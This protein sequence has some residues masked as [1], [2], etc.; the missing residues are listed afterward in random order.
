METKP[1]DGQAR[2]QALLS[3]PN[4][5]K[6][7]RIEP[8]WVEGGAGLAF[9]E[10]SGAAPVVK[11]VESASGEARW[12]LDPAT[13]GAPGPAALASGPSGELL[14]TAGS[15]RF[16]LGPADGAA[17]ELSAED[18]AAIERLTPRVTR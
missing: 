11:L 10:R 13:L 12:T 6:G 7:G 3:D 9:V 8:V 17:S 1:L 15:R 2:Y 18:L 5:V 14:L 4:L 16:K